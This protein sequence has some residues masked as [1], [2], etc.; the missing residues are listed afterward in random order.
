MRK[1]WLRRTAAAALAVCLLTQGAA[2]QVLHKSDLQLTRDLVLSATY[3]QQQEASVREKILSYTPGGE[4]QPVVVYGDTLYGR[5]TMEYIREYLDEQ[6]LSAAAAVNAAFFDMSTGIP[7]GMVVTDGILRSS[8]DGHTV[9]IDEYSRLEITRPMLKVSMLWNDQTIDLNYNKAL[10]KQNGYC[11]YSK[12]YDVRTKNGISA[13]NVILEAEREQLTVSDQVRAV[14]KQIIPETASCSIPQGCFVLSLATDTNYATAM[15]QMKQLA[16][17]DKVIIS[18]TVNRGCENVRYAVGGG[19]LL[20]ENGKALTEFTLESAKRPAARTAIG[21]KANGEVVC[22]TADKS[23]GSEGLTLAE[24]AQRMVELGCVKALN[25]DG[26]GS[27]TAGVTLP[28][29]TAFSI[30]NDPADGAQRPCA[31]FL[32]FV[33]QEAMAGA[34]ARLHLYPYDAAVLPG[35]Q[36]ELSVKATDADYRAAQV[37]AGVVYSASNGTVDGMTFTA[38]APGTARVTAQAGGITGFTEINVVQ[39]PSSMT[40]LDS[41]TGREVKEILMETGGTLDLTVEAEYLGMDLAARDASFNWHVD[42]SLGTVDAEG[43]F[44]AAS[45]GKGTLSVSCGQLTKT[46]AVEVRENPFADTRNHWARSPIAQLYFKGVVQGS[47]G[48]DGIVYYRP[49][50]SMTRQEFVVSMVRASGVK[51][52]KYAEEELPF[53]DADAIASWAVDAV[54]AA[55]GLGWFTGSGKGDSLYA[56]PTATITREAAMTMLARSI[57][58]SSESDALDQFAD[59]GKVSAWAKA[60]MT[61]MVEKGII[62]G[63]DGKLQ[64]QGNVTRA[65]VAKMLYMMQ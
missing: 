58:V 59:A 40:V 52:E 11:L 27:T 16:V 35:G 22:Y 17:G 45:E 29:D 23:S 13:Y 12:D 19:D 41:A 30:I 36:V 60:G 6:N 21:V 37:P 55:Y 61:A 57:S 10:S 2:A 25:L 48:T 65:Q 38:S 39:T 63:M 1:Q 18:T 51:V 3:S 46:V 4:V 26:G 34:A 50:D 43:V 47:G 8:G 5:S 15:E 20:V 31:N 54:K 14:V 32:F 28:G 64:P 7:Y 42:E 44:A 56:Q 33:R 49:D 53:D 62:N 9:C 24:L